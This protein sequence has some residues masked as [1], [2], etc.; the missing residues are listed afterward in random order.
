M[1][2]KKWHFPWIKL[3]EYS[4]TRWVYVL[5]ERSLLPIIINRLKLSAKI[6]LG[7]EWLNTWNVGLPAWDQTPGTINIPTLIWLYNLYKSWGM[8]SYVQARYRLLG[9]GSHWFPG[10]NSD[11]L[12][13]DVSQYDLK[14]VLRS[15]PWPDLIIERL[16]ELRD[17]FGGDTTQRLSKI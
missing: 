2:T 11:G 1:E 17:K 8:E 15:S 5:S 14:Q 13:K 10:A 9:H 3:W 12:D 16:R 6:S 7:Q 4:N